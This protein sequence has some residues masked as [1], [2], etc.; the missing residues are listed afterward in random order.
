MTPDTSTTES[1]GKLAFQCNSIQQ[2]V[3][4]NAIRADSD[5]LY[6]KLLVISIFPSMIRVA[7]MSNSVLE[8]K[9]CVEAF[10]SNTSATYFTEVR[11][12]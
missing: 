5:Y 6:I 9:A 2:Q 11:S 8:L 4:G 3:L 7:H 10:S 1:I 12:K